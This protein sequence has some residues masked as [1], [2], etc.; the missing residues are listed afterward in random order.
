[1][2]TWVKFLRTKDET[3]DVFNNLCTQVQSE[4]E[5]KIL[6]VRSDHGEEF[7]NEPFETFCENKELSKSFLLLELHNKM[8]L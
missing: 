2:W 5:M 3:Y 4:K 7:K 6:K 8:G 1:M